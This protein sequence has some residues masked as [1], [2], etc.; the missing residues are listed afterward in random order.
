MKGKADIT[1]GGGQGQAEGS[2]QHQKAGL[3]WLE[4]NVCVTQSGDSITQ[5][6]GVPVLK[7]VV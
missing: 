4:T 1:Q 2:G 7:V 5:M 6:G 3:W